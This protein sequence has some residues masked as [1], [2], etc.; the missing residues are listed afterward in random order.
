MTL[1]VFYNVISKIYLLNVDKVFMMYGD[2]N[3]E[4]SKFIHYGNIRKN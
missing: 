1:I 4:S 3:M 2:G